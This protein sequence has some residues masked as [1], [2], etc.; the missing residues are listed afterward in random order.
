MLH[1]ILSVSGLELDS[2]FMGFIISILD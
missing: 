1:K 2:R